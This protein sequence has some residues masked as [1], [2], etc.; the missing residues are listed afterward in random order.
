MDCQQ[1]F[2][3]SLIEEKVFWS[4]WDFFSIKTL[5]LKLR[6]YS[7]W[8]MCHFITHIYVNVYP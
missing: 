2:I 6:D 1:T 4:E 5:G 3:K 8:L 7:K